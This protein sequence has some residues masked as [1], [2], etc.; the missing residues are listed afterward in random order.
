[1][2]DPLDTILSCYKHKFDDAG[3]EWSLDPETLVFEY[4]NY[5]ELMAHWRRVLPGRIHEISYEGMVRDQEGTIRGILKKLKL[6][7]DPAVMQYHKS[8]RTVHTHSM[9]QVRHSVYSKSVGGWRKYAKHMKKII[10]VFKRYMPRL[11]AKGALPLPDKM[12]WRFDPDFDYGFG[13]VESKSKS[14]RKSKDGDEMCDADTEE[15][16]IEEE[17]EE[18]EKKGEKEMKKK[19]KKKASS[20][21]KKEK[22]PIQ[23]KKSK[24]KK[25]N[26]S[27]KKNKKKGKK[28]KKFK[29]KKTSNN[30]EKKKKKITKKKK[31]SNNVSS[32]V[33]K[34]HESVINSID[35]NT[36]RRMV[37]N[38]AHKTGIQIIDEICGIGYA[39]VNTRKIR[40]AVN[41]FKQLLAIDKTAAPAFIGYG[42]ALGMGQQ[43]QE[44]LNVFTEMIDL[45]PHLNEPYERRAEVYLGMN[46]V[47]EAKKDF[48]YFIENTLPHESVGARVGRGKLQFQVQNFQSALKDYKAVLPLVSKDQVQTLAFI[49]HG[50]GKCEKEL[51]NTEE[52]VTALTEALKY[53]PKSSEI[54][55]DIA[56]TYIG[57]SLWEE[58]LPYFEEALAIHPKYKM[59]F[60]YRGLMY[61]NLG[62]AK[63]S[64]HDIMMALAADP[65]EPSPMVIGTACLHSLGR[66]KQAAAMYDRMLSLNP[67]H[68]AWFT[69]E[70]LFTIYVHLDDDLSTYNTDRMVDPVVKEGRSQRNPWT[71]V[72]PKSYVSDISKIAREK[73][74]EEGDKPFVMTERIRYILELTSP[75]KKWVQLETPGFMP[76]ERQH[77]Q[78]GLS[79]LQMAQT[80]R[81]HTKLIMAGEEGLLVPDVA[82]SNTE[83]YG[84]T[85]SKKKSGY[86]IFGWR[87]LFDI[88]ARWR[89]ISE[90][91]DVVWWNDGLPVKEENKQYG[92][93]THIVHGVNKVVR[94]YP[95]FDMAFNLTQVLMDKFFYDAKDRTVVPD[96][97]MRKNIAMANSLETLFRVVTPRPF[98][99]VTPCNSLKVPGRSM[100]G[101]RI[102]LTSHPTEGYEFFINSPTTETRKFLYME[103]M[104]FAFHNF[105]SALQTVLK[106]DGKDK[107]ASDAAFDRGLEIFFYWVNYAPLSRGTSAT[108][109]AAL[110]ACVVAMGE[111]I[112]SPVPKGKQLDWEGIL[113]PEPQV[114]VDRVRG[115]LSDRGSSSFSKQWLDSEDGYRL[116]DVFS[117]TR[118]MYTAIGNLDD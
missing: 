29:K 19:K 89:Q 105:I 58:A 30:K 78:F 32:K 1:M 56:V 3:L 60:G 2:R 85:P 106:G 57:A 73:L 114:F 62:R 77:R 87:D 40:E 34:L 33:K 72:F 86:H 111:Q 46:N 95:Y 94:Y 17:K 26:T 10:K 117:T 38:M 37:S 18:E 24:K 102:T 90:P 110:M 39:Y 27:I 91:L 61:Q 4:V 52:S 103:D 36:L 51:G 82:A 15:C 118:S 11:E 22:K 81:Q 76:N 16:S 43:Y 53:Q 88:A 9:Q 23:S 83:W 79:V 28:E 84:F 93:R 42:T 98:Y 66:F 8:N 97:N 69:R 100:E 45:F 47:K 5:I 74:E 63:D 68:D 48:D 109:Y 21:S 31:L 7:W 55:L 20:K 112:L 50:I 54:N 13:P 71:E 80:M 107:Q 108:G 92:L 101:T 6:D 116:S 35:S 49:Y 14:K 75:I 65:N 96:S 59:A 44:A 64:L 67:T 104:D 115:W 41:L 70:V 12:N 113:T 99:V 25:K